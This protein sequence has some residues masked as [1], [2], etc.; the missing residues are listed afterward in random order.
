[1]QVKKGERSRKKN[2]VQTSL[3]KTSV[4]RMSKLYNISPQT[5]RN[6]EYTQP[7]E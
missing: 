3:G 6:I 1:M 5:V 7:S 4:E 2:L